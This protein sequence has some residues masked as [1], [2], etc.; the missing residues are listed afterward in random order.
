ML[1]TAC[2][3][4]VN[5]ALIQAWL[6]WGQLATNWIMLIVTYDMFF[7]IMTRL[8]S[9]IIYIHK[10]Y[11]TCVNISPISVDL[12]SHPWNRARLTAYFIIQPVLLEQRKWLSLN[13]CAFPQFTFWNLTLGSLF[14]MSNNSL[15]NFSWL[16]EYTSEVNYSS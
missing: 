10:F 12:H 5:L 2:S 3:I 8:I 13:L 9:Y 11:N 15:G 7:L 6:F 16:W 1:A 14:G 4:L